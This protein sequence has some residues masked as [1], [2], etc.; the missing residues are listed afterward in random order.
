MILKQFYLGCLSQA[1][2]LIGDRKTGTAAVVDPR[3][4][5]GI[6]EDFARRAGLKIKHALLTHFHA[7]FAAGHLELRARGARI[8]LGS[9]AKAAYPFTP[10]KEGD[11]LR[12]GD[13][14]IQALETPGHTPE[15]LSFL[16]FDLSRSARAPK[17]VLTGDTLF[18]GD[19]GRPDLLVSKGLSA[20]S[21]AG[22]LYDSLHEKLLPLPDST[23]VYP[24]HGAGSLCGKNLSSD[25]VSTLGLQRRHNYALQPMSRKRFVGLVSREQPPAPSY[26]LHGVRHNRSRR[27][28]LESIL[29]K[30]LSP[31]PA[32]RFLAA[33]RK[34][35]VLDTRD[36][37][38]FESAH[39]A[40]AVNVGLSGRFASWAGAVLD[41]NRPILLICEPGTEKEAA[42]RL[43]RIGLDGV[44]GFLK[45]G[46]L[47]LQGHPGKIVKTE[48]MTASALAES[49][50]SRRRPLVLDVRAPG[51]WSSARIAGSLN[52]PLDRLPGR[53]G[54]LPP[55]RPVVVHCQGGYRSA[56]AAGLL[57]RAGVKT[58]ADLVGG[59]AA[60]QAAGFPT[61]GPKTQSSQA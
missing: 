21:L 52:I 48:R 7:D 11:A 45:G 4:D 24:A 43:G 31:L 51:E 5:V 61:L 57:E 47:A 8:Y 12:F 42:L 53:T 38:D 34:A 40:G 56:V 19:V 33:A 2:Y 17:A 6:Y 30:A 54:E 58:V 37:A 36:A 3:R 13:V 50:K 22:M 29:R 32:G 16:V 41:P 46:M 15:G 20:K 60:W 25:T 39:L 14:R 27:P 1:S 49:L 23:L 10:L 26:F 9:R 44:S 28:T 35:Q 59:I 18:I 55:G